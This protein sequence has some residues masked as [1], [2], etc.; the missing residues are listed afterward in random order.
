VNVEESCFLMEVK[1]I[2]SLALKQLKE[3]PPE[4]IRSP[5]ERPENTKAIE[6]VTVPLISLSHPHNLL[7]KEISEAASE[8]G[9]FQITHHN[10]SQ[11]LIQS[12]REVG[13]EFFGLPQ[14]EKE[15]YANDPSN[16]KFDGYGTKM[17]KNLEEK[18]EWLDYFFHLISPP[19]KLNYHM[20]PKHPSSYRCVYHPNILKV[21][22]ILH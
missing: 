2:Q 8:W 10:I 1:R 4:F 6:G 20:W 17:T 12:L 19:S 3:V 18:M 5:N 13:E 16:G 14:E 21:I 15:G 9:F 11:T 22:K 7:V